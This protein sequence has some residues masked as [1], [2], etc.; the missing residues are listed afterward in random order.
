MNFVIASQS[1][2]NQFSII[3]WLLLGYSQDFFFLREEDS[4]SKSVLFAP[5]QQEIILARKNV[6]AEFI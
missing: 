4:I 3:P 1:S 6:S 2:V 5:I